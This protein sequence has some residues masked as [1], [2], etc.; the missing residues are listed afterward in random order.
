MLKIRFLFVLILALF[1]P[2]F[3]TA[4]IGGG[5]WVTKPV[6]AQESVED[7]RA[8]LQKELEEEERQIAIQSA[9]LRAKQSETRTVTGDI[10]LLI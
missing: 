8:R 9:L 6:W 1:V 3:L 10:N 2:L 7:R 5:S 4:L